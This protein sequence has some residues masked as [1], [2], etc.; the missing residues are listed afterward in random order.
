MFSLLAITTS[1][2]AATFSANITNI[3]KDTVISDY[4][5]SVRLVNA[6]NSR[7]K[8]TIR[9]IEGRTNNDGFFKG[10]IETTAGKVLVAEV[11][12][13]G[14][15]Y[16]SKPTI[17]N[18]NQQHYDLAVEVFEITS[19]HEEVSMPIRKMVI[20]PLDE[21]TLEV[22]DN[23][24]INNS[25][26]HTYVGTFN[27]G[28]DVTQVLNIP[29][30]ASYK[31]RG[32]QAGFTSA[33]IR[34]LGRAIVSQKE[35]RPGTSQIS[36][37]Y[38]V[39]SDIGF[40]DLSLFS[41]K[42]TPEIQDMSLYFPVGNKWQVKPAILKSAGEEVWGNKNYRVWKGRPGS[43]L[44]LKAYS[45][46]Y[47]G[48]FNFWYMAMIMGFLVAGICL[49]LAREKIKLWY[50]TQEEKKLKKLQTMLLRE[51]DNQELTDYYQPL[52][53]MLDSRLQEA[54]HIIKGE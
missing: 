34:T 37:R 47:T 42:D 21:R 23:L 31:L 28:L 29:M 36:I 15:E 16:L 14:L 44:R 27:D 54:K 13:R 2:Y 26:N 1:G 17:L 33:K 45:P 20:T 4:P 43:I 41:E 38:I 39:V 10:E 12:Y 32:I 6:N 35:V 3:T 24:L 49:L 30:P 7:Q 18:D 48:G 53:L 8:G 19:S 25:G 46:D 9:E 11:N 22:Y 51:T 40:F 5:I 52:R 50:L